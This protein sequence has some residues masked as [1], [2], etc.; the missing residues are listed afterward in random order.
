LPVKNAA[1]AEDLRELLQLVQ[2]VVGALKHGPMPPPAFTE[3]FERGALGPR[4]SQPLLTLAREGTMSVS[5]LAESL[6]LSLSA[7]SLMVGEL[8]R[9]GLLDRSEDENDRR[10]T[11]VQLN[12]SIKADTTAW[13]ADRIDPFRRTLE[14]L[15]PGERAD[16][17]KGWRVLAEE[18]TSA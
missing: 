6:N 18:M 7:T 17:L 10:R 3:A 1:A 9:A 15:S 8:S 2:Q 12:D 16:F 14:R 13:L 11:V 4:H 5:E